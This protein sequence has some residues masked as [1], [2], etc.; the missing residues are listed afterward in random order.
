MSQGLRS[1]DCRAVA[2]LNGNAD[3]SFIDK[4]P[5]TLIKKGEIT[6]L[7]LRICTIGRI[8]SDLWPLLS[9]Q[10]YTP[11]ILWCTVRN[12][13]RVQEDRISISGLIDANLTS[14]TS[15]S[16]LGSGAGKFVSSAACISMCSII[17]S[18]MVHISVQLKSAW[19]ITG[20]IGGLQQVRW[21]R[22]P[23]SFCTKT[24]CCSPRVA[25]PA[26][27]ELMRKNPPFCFGRW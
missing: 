3:A 21:T 18:C 14:K 25:Q 19:R 24:R 13:Y 15:S 22:T 8:Y 16:I 4:A 1:S 11:K 20:F 27:N 17:S 10:T 9:Q 7:L 2:K 12:C 26:A 23:T 5:Q 6:S